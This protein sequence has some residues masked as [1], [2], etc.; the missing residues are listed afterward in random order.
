MPTLS[1]RPYSPTAS[2]NCPTSLIRL[3]TFRVFYVFFL[4]IQKDPRMYFIRNLTCQ[5]IFLGYVSTVIMEQSY[6]YINTMHRFHSIYYLV[7]FFIRIKMPHY[8]N[9]KTPIAMLPCF[10]DSV[11]KSMK[12]L[13]LIVVHF[14]TFCLNQRMQK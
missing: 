9:K 2:Y 3:N 6:K 12:A 14:W 11:V 1:N 10:I 4:T 8:N 5:S 13:N 7:G